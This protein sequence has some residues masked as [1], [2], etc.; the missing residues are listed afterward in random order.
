M[1]KSK[2]LP[3]RQPKKKKSGPSFRTGQGVLVRGEKARIVGPS[4]RK[5]G[6]V[7]VR[8]RITHTR[9]LE[10]KLKKQ[11]YELLSQEAK[12]REEGNLKG[13]SAEKLREIQKRIHGIKKLRGYWGYN[14]VIT[15]TTTQTFSV[16]ERDI[17]IK[18]TKKPKTQ[19]VSKTQR[20]KQRRKALVQQATRRYRNPKTRKIK[21]A[22]RG[23][24]EDFGESK[25]TKRKRKKE[26]S[27]SPNFRY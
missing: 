16:P 25:G 2:N 20:K 17:K 27:R 26:F 9:H 11:L 21:L 12:I 15:T 8:K 1:R 10:R 22:K 18:K 3:K 14:P 19:K 23:I 24:I 13:S 7:V 6:K 4:K 5:T